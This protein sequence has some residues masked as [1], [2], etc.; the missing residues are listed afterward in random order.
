VKLTEDE[1]KE[2]KK[3]TE[4][5]RNSRFAGSEAVVIPDSL[6]G[7][8]TKLFN[9]ESIKQGENKLNKLSW[10]YKRQQEL[11]KFSFPLHI[12]CTVSYKGE[13]KGY[14]TEYDYYTESLA[15]ICLLK[16]EKIFCLEKVKE[17]VYLT[18]YQKYI[19]EENNIPYTTCNTM[20]ELLFLLSDITDDEELESVARQIE[21]FHYYNETKK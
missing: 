4:K 12:L 16:E 19:L 17:N 8:A 21:E 15:S 20:N 7:L 11:E 3:K 18:K 2:L 9:E 1:Y 6:P 10:L 14:D 13:L 5:Y